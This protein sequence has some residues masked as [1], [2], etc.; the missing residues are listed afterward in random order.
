MPRSFYPFMTIDQLLQVREFARTSAPLLAASTASSAQT[1]AVA[2]RAKQLGVT[3]EA[4]YRALSTRRPFTPAL[5]ANKSLEATA[6]LA[7]ELEGVKIGKAP[8][9]PHQ[10]ITPKIEI[11]GVS[12][13]MSDDDDFSK[14]S[15]DEEAA[16]LAN[17]GGAAPAASEIEPEP[18]LSFFTSVLPPDFNFLG[19]P[20]DLYHGFLT[21]HV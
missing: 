11:F 16:S 3:C 14:S 5:P 1:L 6:A 13:D 9:A 17:G 7:K 10:A 21:L 8:A 15:V 12:L 20:K 18:E 2:D 4:S 19:N